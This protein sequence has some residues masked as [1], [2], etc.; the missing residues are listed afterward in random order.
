MDNDVNMADES[1]RSRCTADSRLEQ[2]VGV[3]SGHR[4]DYRKKTGGLFCNRYIY[5]RGCQ[6]HAKIAFELLL[7]YHAV[8]CATM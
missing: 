2:A 4:L 8:T 3:P 7:T 5:E 1:F 6:L